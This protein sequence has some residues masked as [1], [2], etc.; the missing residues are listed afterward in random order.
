MSTWQLFNCPGVARV[1]LVYNYVMML[2]FTFT[3]VNPVFQYTSIHR[4]GIGFTPELIAAFTALAGAAQATWLLLVFPRLHKR[5][6]T[7]KVLFYCAC[8][9]PVFFASS[10]VFNILLRYHLR[11]VF[12]A[13]APLTLALGSGVAMAFSASLFASLRVLC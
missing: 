4:G 9:W 11:A 2:A 10:V 3:A 7:G 8:A 6:G 1:V 12:W 13:T 5:V